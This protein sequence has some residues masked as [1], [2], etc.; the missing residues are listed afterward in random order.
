[1]KIKVGGG[2]V[3]EKGKCEADDFTHAIKTNVIIKTTKI[4][5]QNQLKRSENSTQQ[6]KKSVH[7]R[8]E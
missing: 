1:M 4:I 2:K 5:L 3:A 6:R 7:E 8:E